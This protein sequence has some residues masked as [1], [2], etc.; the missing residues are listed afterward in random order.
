MDWKIEP[1]KWSDADEAFADY[2]GQSIK[3][4][5]AAFGIPKS[6]IESDFDSLSGIDTT[7]MESMIELSNQNVLAYVNRQ[8]FDEIVC[9]CGSG[10]RH[11][12]ESGAIFC[13]AMSGRKSPYR[14]R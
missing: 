3:F 14:I 9:R 4:L 12:T 1:V 2:Q 6:L 11:A 10:H 13:D 5:T 7:V 8:I